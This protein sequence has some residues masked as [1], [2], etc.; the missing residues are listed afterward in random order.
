MR[1]GMPLM[2]FTFA[3][4]YGILV[5]ALTY[6]FHVI[7]AG[8]LRRGRLLG[9]ALLSTLLAGIASSSMT[10]ALGLM[11][12]DPSLVAAMLC[13]GGLQG[14]GGGYLSSVLWTRYFPY[15]K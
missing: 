7:E 14:L 6:L 13:V 4:L 12:F 8:Q 11:P 15:V 5:S 1:G 2:T 3:L 9:A 10:I